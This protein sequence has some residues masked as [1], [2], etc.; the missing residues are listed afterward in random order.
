MNPVCKF[1]EVEYTSNYDDANNTMQANFDVI[2]KQDLAAKKKGSLV[3]RFIQEQIADGHAFYVIMAESK[4]KVDISVVNGI[5]DDWVIP[6][7]GEDARIDKAY[8][9]STIQFRD[10]MAE[11][12][13]RQKK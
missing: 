1:P 7:W 11:L 3:G 8:A 4:T 10:K 5:G 2:E 9:I 12:F 6:Y 13:A